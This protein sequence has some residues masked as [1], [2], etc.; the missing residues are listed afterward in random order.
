MTISDVVIIVAVLA[1]P[2]L[3]VQVQK[4][5]E[6]RREA[7]YR[8][9][10]L[11]R[12]LMTS[13]ANRV[14]IAHVEALNTIDLEFG[15]SAPGDKPVR[16]AWRVY[17]DHLNTRADDVGR[18]NDKNNELFIELLHAMARSLGYDFDKVLL[19]RGLYSPQA[20]G[21]EL[22]YIQAVR[23]ALLEV[24]DGKRPIPIRT[25]DDS[26]GITPEDRSVGPPAHDNERSST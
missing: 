5:L 22:L 16:D 19:K 23:K 24:L 7:R 3:A 4:W 21:D 8:R 9:L 1:G 15:T 11:F 14:S 12:T 13:R 17:H 26:Q 18:W 10:A 2:L 25:V 6:A 20:H